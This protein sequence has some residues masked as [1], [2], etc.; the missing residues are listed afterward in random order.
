M[1]KRLFDLHFELG[2]YKKDYYTKH[3]L[4]N[5]AMEFCSTQPFIYDSLNEV[6]HEMEQCGAFRSMINDP[7]LSAYP[8]PAHISTYKMCELHF[9]VGMTPNS[10]I[11][12]K[13][14]FLKWSSS[15][16][17]E[18]NT[19]GGAVSASMFCACD[20]GA[21]S[22]ILGNPSMSVYPLPFQSATTA[23][24]G[25]LASDKIARKLP[26]ELIDQSH[27]NCT[28][29]CTSMHHFGKNKCKSMCAWRTEVL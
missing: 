7:S 19:I 8:I 10:L 5:N 29:I 21:I 13:T 4:G 27:P 28:T 26:N 20:D 23:T 9:E 1:D 16:R 14:E 12:A 2:C 24:R 25:S 15:Y 11:Y 18:F 17:T 22:A 3:I 6:V